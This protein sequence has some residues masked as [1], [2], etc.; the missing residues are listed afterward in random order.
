MQKKN[1]GLFSLGIGIGGAWI[2]AILIVFLARRF[3]PNMTANL[4]IDTI[5]ITN[6]ISVA[7]A[8]FAFSRYA[9]LHE[10]LLEF[11][12]FSFLIGGFMRV[13][14]IVVSDTV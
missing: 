11:I 6:M 1:K 10:R 2:F 13:V 8:L 9:V 3:H 14:G 4:L 12:A 5:L 7:I